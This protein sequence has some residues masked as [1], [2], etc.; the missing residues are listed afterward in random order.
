MWRHIMLLAFL[1]L[2]AGALSEATASEEM[3]VE[4]VVVDASSPGSQPEE[5]I[6]QGKKLGK[7]GNVDAFLSDVVPGWPGWRRHFWTDKELWGNQGYIIGGPG[8]RL[9]F[10][11]LD[12]AGGL[13]IGASEP[14]LEE[15]GIPE[16]PFEPVDLQT[17]NLLPDSHTVVKGECLWYIAGYPRIYDNPLQWPIIYKANRDRIKHP[18]LIYPGQVFTIPRD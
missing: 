8:A 6:L 1:G 5:A 17:E 11:D 18:D 4:E 12:I 14:I 13:E 10:G 16:A 7:S 3:V 9:D 2:S 15:P